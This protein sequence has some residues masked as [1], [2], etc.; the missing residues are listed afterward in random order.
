[1]EHQ[2]R[3][4]ALVQQANSLISAANYQGDEI[5]SCV[6]KVQGLID[7][8]TKTTDSRRV[9]LD[10]SFKFLQFTREADSIEAWMGDKE[11]QTTSEDFGKDL[12]SAQSLISKQDT[13][14]ASIVAFQ[15]RVDSFSALKR[16]LVAQS[17]SHSA[18]VSARELSVMARWKALIESS[19]KRKVRDYEHFIIAT[20][21]DLVQACRVSPDSRKDRRALPHLCQ[22]GVG[23]QQLV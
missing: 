22:E 7:T 19:D 3:V 4:K 10:D 23:V 18:A 15:P 2:E 8:L 17:N 5:Q 21:V 14:H 1:M 13:F 11:P 16:D 6:K 20:H 9:A 12:P